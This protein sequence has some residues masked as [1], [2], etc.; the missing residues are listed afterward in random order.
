MC[1]RAQDKGVMIKK[2]MSY[3]ANVNAIIDDFYV[4]I[5]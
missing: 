3:E 1:R 4:L 5:R 2:S